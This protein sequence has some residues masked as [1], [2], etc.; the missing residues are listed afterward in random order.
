MTN[1]QKEKMIQL[2]PSEIS[3]DGNFAVYIHDGTGFNLVEYDKDVFFTIYSPYQNIYGLVI[4]T[5]DNA[6]IKLV[7]YGFGG[8]PSF[9]VAMSNIMTINSQSMIVSSQM[10]AGFKEL[11]NDT[12]KLAVSPEVKVDRATGIF[13]E[14]ERLAKTNSQGV[15]YSIAASLCFFYG[16]HIENDGTILKIAN[17]ILQSS[18]EAAFFF[19]QFQRTTRGLLSPPQR[20]LLLPFLRTATE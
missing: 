4:K 7:F 8:T 15:D 20:F 3:D 14:L 10:L 6:I 18:I 17:K 13:S 9:N 2:L 1:E 19:S 16:N 11:W 12:L 5:F